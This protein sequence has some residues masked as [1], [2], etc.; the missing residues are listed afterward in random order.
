MARK[1]KR[2]GSVT[3]RRRSYPRRRVVTTYTRV[4]LSNPKIGGLLMNGLTS[5]VAS[6]LTGLLT[7]KLMGNQ[8]TGL[9]ALATVGI[10]VLGAIL[11]RKRPA[12]ADAFQ[13]GAMGT[14]AYAF[15]V[16]AA[17]GVVATNKAD[18]LALTSKIPDAKTSA[19]ATDTGQ[20]GMGLLLPF[21]QRVPV[22]QGM[23]YNNAAARNLT[24]MGAPMRRQMVNP[25]ALLG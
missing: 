1:R 17:G 21:N 22:G 3:K 16:N 19:T 23:L 8:S 11:L 10:G 24:G 2:K 14:L 20:K 25:R 15:A 5:N 9:R 18:A 13:A 6:G 12:A 4:T 7:T